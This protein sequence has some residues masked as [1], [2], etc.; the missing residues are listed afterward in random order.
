MMLPACGWKMSQRV[1][2]RF[3]YESFKTL[4]GFMMTSLWQVLKYRNRKLKRYIFLIFLF[5]FCFLFCFVLFCFVFT[6]KYHIS[7]GQTS[8]IKV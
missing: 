2:L 8:P 1:R 5:I 6:L 7:A 4:Q 3:V